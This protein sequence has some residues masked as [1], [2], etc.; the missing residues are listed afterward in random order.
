[1]SDQNLDIA[2]DRVQIHGCARGRTVT[3]TGSSARTA[4]PDDTVG[5]SMNL[6]SHHESLSG[7]RGPAGQQRGNHAGDGM[8]YAQGADRPT[9]V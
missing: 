6:V 4:T 7:P 8:C 3:G 1:M 2:A 5:G 9:R